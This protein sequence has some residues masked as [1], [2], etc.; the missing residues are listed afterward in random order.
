MKFAIFFILL[1]LIIISCDG[2]RSR[3]HNQPKISSKANITSP[4]IIDANYSFKEAL[5]GTKAPD[6]VISQ[7]ELIEVQ[8]F[9]TDGKLHQGQLL[10]NKRIVTEL[11]EIFKFIK[12]NKFPVAKVIPAVKYNWC[13]K[14][15]MQDNNTYC[16]NYRNISYSKHASGLA[17]DINP[18][19]NP[20]RWKYPYSNRSSEPAGAV[21]DPSVRGTF[22]DSSEVVRELRRLGFRWGHSFSKNYDDHHFEF[23]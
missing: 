14:A 3:L 12:K 4:I 17:I 1:P 15:S 10:C 19:Y 16:F 18:Y 20:I 5:L 21:Y 11:L 8:Y 13:D 6:S 9:S 2:A 22:C 7:L 23:R